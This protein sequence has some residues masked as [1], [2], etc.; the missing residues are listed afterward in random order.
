MNIQLKEARDRI[1]KNPKIITSHMV[2]I[3]D[4][5][6]SMSKADMNGHKSRARGVYYN[7]AEDVISVRLHPPEFGKIGGDNSTFT[8]VVTLIEMRNEATVVFEREPISWQLYNRFC[9]LREQQDTRQ[10]GNYYPSFQSA[11]GILGA[12]MSDPNCA[13]CIFFFSDGAPSDFSTSSK[14]SWMSKENTFPNNLNSLVRN[15]CSLYRSRLTLTAY[16]FGKSS[17]N[18]SVMQDLIDIAKQEGVK[19]SFGQSAFDPNTLSTLL[20]STVTSLTETRTLLSRLTI[21]SSDAPR[22]KVVAEKEMF[23]PSDSLFD[24]KDWEFFVP[25]TAININRVDLNYYKESNGIFKGKWES[26]RFAE[27]SAVGFAVGRKYFGEGAER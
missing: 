5:S 14:F 3:V 7:I 22:L 27:H 15:E 19:A 17:T 20:S 25:T 10:H 24:S 12:H 11:F 1:R 9:S 2:L 21:A 18:F 16:G 23:V 4:M 8:D 6:T 26:I 13:L